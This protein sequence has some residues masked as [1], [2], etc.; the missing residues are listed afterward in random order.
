[1]RKVFIN[2]FSKIFSLTP[3][4][5]ICSRT[6]TTSSIYFCSWVLISETSVVVTSSANT[7]TEAIEGDITE[8]S[9]NTT[10]AEV[11]IF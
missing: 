4:L 10:G 1:M 2:I 7:L 8:N 3:F 6:L 9:D 11:T 5:N